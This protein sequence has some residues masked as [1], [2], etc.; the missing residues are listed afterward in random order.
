MAGTEPPSSSPSPSSCWTP[1]TGP[2]RGS[3]SSWRRSGST[4]ATRWLIGESV[5]ACCNKSLN[6]LLQLWPGSGLHRCQRAK[7]NISAVVG[8]RPSGMWTGLVS[9]RLILNIPAPA[10]VSLSLR[11]QPDLPAEAGRAHLLQPLRQLPC[12]LPG[13]EETTEN[14]RAN[15]INLGL[16]EKS[17]Q[18]VPEL[19]ICQT[20]GGPVAEV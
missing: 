10:P 3:R 16:L 2:W 6:M 7:S 13:G 20:R 4:S 17:P 8:L 12:Q 5:S 19:P 1:T 14:Q 15:Q 9:F 18:Q 11:V